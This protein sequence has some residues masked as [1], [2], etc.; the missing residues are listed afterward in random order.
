MTKSTL[1]NPKY[2][3]LDE[4][5]VYI[6][7]AVLSDEERIL[8][9]WISYD[10]VPHYWMYDINKHSK[11]NTASYPYEVSYFMDSYCKFL[12]HM[13]FKLII[14]LKNQELFIRAY[15]KVTFGLFL[16]LIS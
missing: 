2:I 10:G 1:I 8:V 3:S 11:L 7:A 15:L 4:N 5:V 9:G 13:D 14:T 12:F 6:K 16:E